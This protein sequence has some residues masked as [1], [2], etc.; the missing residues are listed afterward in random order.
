MSTIAKVFIVLNFVLSIFFV[1]VAS[2]LLYKADNFKKKYETEVDTHNRE[3]AAK[4]EEIKKLTTELNTS[5]TS[6]DSATRAKEEV[7]RERDSLKKDKG[8]L[9]TKTAQLQGM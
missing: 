2:T 8:D 3:V 1:G 5:Q 9:D 6:V 7:T 4:Q